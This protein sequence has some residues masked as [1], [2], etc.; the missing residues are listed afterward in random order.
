MSLLVSWLRKQENYNRWRGADTFR[1][2][3]KES[4][5]SEIRMKLICNGITSRMNN[6]IKSKIQELHQ[7]YSIFIYA[8]SIFYATQC[9]G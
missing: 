7:K 1:G 3:S 2:E 8:I 5:C 9:L 6:D 4:L